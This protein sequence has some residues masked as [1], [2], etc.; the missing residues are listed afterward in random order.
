MCL[1]AVRAG[2]SVMVIRGSAAGMVPW[3]MLVGHMVERE[4]E[5]YVWG[6]VV[7]RVIASMIWGHR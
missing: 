6:P 5:E 7:G 4:Y 1:L 3:L 2:E